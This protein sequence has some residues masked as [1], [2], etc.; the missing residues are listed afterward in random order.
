MWQ[1]IIIVLVMLGVAL[2]AFIL[3]AMDPKLT[4]YLMLLFVAASLARIPEP[5]QQPVA[6]VKLQWK[7]HFI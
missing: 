5:P 1:S 7:G 3:S 4:S 2:P 6:E